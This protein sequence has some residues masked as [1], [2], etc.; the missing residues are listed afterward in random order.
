MLVLV[1]RACKQP[2]KTVEAVRKMISDNRR[3]T[4][5]EVTDDVGI[6]IG[7]CQAILTDVLGMKRKAAKIV[8][9][10]LNLEYKQYRMDIAQEM[11]TM[12]NEDPELLKK[13]ITGDESW[14]Y[15]YDIESKWKA[16]CYD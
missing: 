8:T 15:G 12:F 16:S 2:M 3:I 14:V 9:K 4:I 7:S 6:S 11:L 13:F 5:I 10:F 1:T